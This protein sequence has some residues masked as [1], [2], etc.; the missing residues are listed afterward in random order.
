MLARSEPADLLCKQTKVPWRYLHEVLQGVLHAQ[1]VQS[2]SRSGQS[3]RKHLAI[4]KDFYADTNERTSSRLRAVL[5]CSLFQM[6]SC[7]FLLE[8]VMVNSPGVVEVTFVSVFVA[9]VLG[10]GALICADEATVPQ[11]DSG[12]LEPS[13]V[14]TT[15]DARR[16]AKVLH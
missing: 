3:G 14:L 13:P 4:Q 15:E 2:H 12:S 11:S 5:C 8:C 9:A 1:L 10:F 7:A 16:Q 6:L